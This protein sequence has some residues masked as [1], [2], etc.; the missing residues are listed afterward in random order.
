MWT[1]LGIGLAHAPAE[2]NISE[3]ANEYVAETHRGICYDS[4]PHT[5]TR[6]A[7]SAGDHVM[8]KYHQQS[9]PVPAPALAPAIIV[10]PVPQTA[11][12][13]GQNA[14]TNL[15]GPEYRMDAVVDEECE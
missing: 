3:A 14:T 12:A 1:K 2:R 7:I 13:N 4:V 8:C 10:P 6:L 11:A 5:H 9:V 15:N